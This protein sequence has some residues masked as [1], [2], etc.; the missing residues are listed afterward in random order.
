MNAGE[1]GWRVLIT[2]IAVVLLLCVG[3][4]W[5]LASPLG[6]TPDEDF[7]LTS[8][9]CSRTAPANSCERTGVSDEAGVEQ[10]V[11]PHALARQA[12]TCYAFHPAVSA[13]CQ[14]TPGA[15]IGDRSRANDGLYP[16]GV[17][18]LMGFL[19]TDH[20]SASVLAMRMMSWVLCVGL[21][22]VAALLATPST[23]RAFVIAVVVTVVPMSVYLFASVNPS[24]VVIAAV[25]SLW[26]ASYTFMSPD[27]VGR[28]LVGA[29]G[30][31]VV[32]ALVGMATRT[33]AG[34]FAAIAVGTAW[35]LHGGF[36]DLRNRR[37]LLL[38]AIALAGVISLTSGPVAG[39][40]SSGLGSHPDRSFAVVLF[41][42]VIRLPELLVGGLGLSS[43]GWLDTA[44]PTIVYVPTIMAVASVVTIGLRGADSQRAR[45]VGL[46]TL[47]IAVLPL[48]V[49]LA[50]RD[51]VGEN[52][53]ARYLLPLLLVVVGST[54]LPDRGRPPGRFGRTHLV[55]LAVAISVAHA[56]AL[57]VTLRRYITGLDDPAFDLDA[58]RE[59]WWPS[60]A[61]TPMVV[62]LVG[63][64]A[65]AVVCTWLL[66]VI[67]GDRRAPADTVAMHDEAV[68]PR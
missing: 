38:G 33:D 26:C 7:H 21:L 35:L 47:A 31:A 6:S 24:G 22:V 8:I 15:T 46:V 54:L 10:V 53:Q 37:T 25:A 43:L 3:G 57:H 41:Q 62:W 36:R 9:W 40:A 13:G 48:Y 14:S 34:M 11:I 42:D 59:W 23:R 44:L 29:G 12:W 51:F 68:A 60:R 18:E 52:V 61:P 65:F 17:Y 27:V 58:D 20:V 56:V 1:R 28:R 32:A 64:I 30:L 67:A 2:A 19:V 66:I 55:V 4:A 39:V 5:A 63:S 50:G 49:L 16:G 45:C